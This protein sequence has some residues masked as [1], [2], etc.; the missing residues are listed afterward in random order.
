MRGLITEED[1]A[2]HA[3]RIFD[4]EVIDYRGYQVAGQL[5]C[6]GY[7]TIAEALQILEGY[8]LGKMGFQ[9]TEVTHLIIEALRRALVDRLSFLGDPDL[10]PVPLKGAVSRGYAEAR[11]ATIDLERATPDE[12]P[13][14]PWPFEPDRDAVYPE[15]AGI[16]G[17]GQTTHISVV[18]KDRNV[19]SLTSTLGAAFGSGVVIKGAG[20]TLNNAVTWF[21]PRPG[22]VT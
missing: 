12:G 16:T 4:P 1:L 5:I 18:D 22:A 9:S 20:I 10:A 19:V 14:D 21:D 15:R 6:S 2:A 13:G 8:D 11:R 17:E 3:T 7:P